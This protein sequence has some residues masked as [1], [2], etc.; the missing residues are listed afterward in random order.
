MYKTYLAAL[1]LLV[2]AVFPAKAAPFENGGFDNQQIWPYVLLNVGDQLIAP[3]QVTKG[4]VDLSSSSMWQAHSEPNTMDLLGD[5]ST[6]VGEISQTFTT[7][8][9]KKYQ[10][11]FI[12][13]GNPDAL[14]A[15]KIIDAM[16]SNSSMT[17]P[18]RFS[19]DIKQHGT[20][21]GNMKWEE[22]SFEFIA[23]GASVTLSFAGSV[24]GGVNSGYGPI[25]D[26]VAVTEKGSTEPGDDADSDC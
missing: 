9:G 16:V 17:K 4:N 18:V 11:G 12:M 7:V 22:H 21:R 24:E 19:Y 15:V 26:S 6:N 2:S 5:G 20:T 10:V 23:N 1:V 3:W 8:P 25:L 13:S 14:P